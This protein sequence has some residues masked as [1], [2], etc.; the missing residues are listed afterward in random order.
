MDETFI[1]K[2]KLVYQQRLNLL[3][4]HVLRKAVKIA[5]YMIQ[6][7]L[8][9]ILFYIEK[10]LMVPETQPENEAVW[11]KCAHTSGTCSVEIVH[12]PG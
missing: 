4:I 9:R 5:P 7:Q 8:L 11:T 12:A 2:W 3:A 10:L 1:I 6:W